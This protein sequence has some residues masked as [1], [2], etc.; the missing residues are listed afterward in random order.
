VIY[1]VLIGPVDYLVLRRFRR[2]ERTWIT[3]PATAVVFALILVAVGF[4]MKRSTALV[5]DVLIEDHLG[6]AD[7][8][9]A[10]S[11]TTVTLPDKDVIEAKIGT[12]EATLRAID[13]QVGR[14]GR[15]TE[16]RVKDWEFDYGSVGLAVGEWCEPGSRLRVERAG[17]DRIRIVNDTGATL[18]DASYVAGGRLWML[19]LI[20]VGETFQ[21]LGS[22]AMV[23]DLFRSYLDYQNWNSTPRREDEWA[24]YGRGLVRRMSLAPPADGTRNR[25]GIAAALDV[26]AWLADGGGVLSGWSDGTPVIELSRGYGQRR[27]YRLVRAFTR[28]D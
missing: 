17:P 13:R 3:F 19:D 27:V 7:L 6:E 1:A 20:P 21:N 14:P 4:S 8:V 9:R 5:R 26:S 15:I 22:G 12:R 24:A 16:G 23:A 28:H 2:L 25:G 11:L 10:W 18:G